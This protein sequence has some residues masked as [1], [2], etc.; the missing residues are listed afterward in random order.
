[1]NIE[2]LKKQ[3]PE[4]YQAAVAEGEAKERDRV[5]AHLTMGEKFK[6]MPTAI[7]AI[8]SGE[9]LT[10][11][12][13]ETYIEAA[14][15]RLEQRA[16]Q[17]DSDAAGAA[18]EG[19]ARPKPTDFDNSDRVAAA[20]GLTMPKPASPH[21][22]ASPTAATCQTRCWRQGRRR[23]GVDPVKT[24]SFRWLLQH[25]PEAAVAM[26][27]S[28]DGDGAKAESNWQQ[29]QQEIV[30]GGI[31]EAVATERKR[32]LDH[33]RLATLAGVPELAGEGYDSGKTA[34]EMR[35][36]YLLEASQH[37]PRKDPTLGTQVRPL[38]LAITTAALSLR[39]L[40]VVS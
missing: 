3:H 25:H 38:A 1:M 9:G 34:D 2:T 13:T 35:D 18:L 17:L 28:N 21:T 20:M 6:E 10:S 15:V 24:R 26:L 23:H 14:T 32:A 39:R 7:A 31:A 8:R 19:A 27:D 37:A 11:K 5:V 16:Y 4:A 40:E 36:F 29:L 22:Q 12:L 30:A 33:V